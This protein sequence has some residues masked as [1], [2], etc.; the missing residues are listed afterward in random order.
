MA[1]ALRSSKVPPDGSKCKQIPE[2]LLRQCSI[3]ILKTGLRSLSE[4]HI[5]IKEE[6]RDNLGRH[7]RG[8][9]WLKKEEIGRYWEN[10][11]CP[12]KAGAEQMHPSG[13][14]AILCRQLTPQLGFW[15][16][17]RPGDRKASPVQ[18]GVCFPPG[19]LLSLP[20]HCLVWGPLRGHIFSVCHT[21]LGTC[22]QGC[23][24]VAEDRRPLPDPLIW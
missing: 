7:Q 21:G 17:K 13:R 12:Q 18:R 14:A 24:W 8:N 9:E 5:K 11:H 23:S 2:P 10:L 6:G 16:H 19:T 20:K 3:L 15:L 1:K 22:A 4:M